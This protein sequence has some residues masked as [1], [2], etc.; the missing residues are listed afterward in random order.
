[1]SVP[2][3][4]LLAALLM[5]ASCGGAPPVQDEYYSLVLAGEGGAAPA[6]DGR[7]L[8]VGP[9]ELPDYLRRRG[10]PLQVD[11]VRIRTAN[12]HFWAEPL[13]E[14]IAKV[15]VTEIAA[16]SGM[17]VDRDAGRWTPA[18]DCRLRIEF[19]R[20]HPTNAAQ[21]TVSGRFWL[22]GQEQMIVREF[23]AVRP[24][25]SDGYATAV[26][27]LREA[28]DGVATTVV[29]ALDEVPDCRSTN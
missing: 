13:D 29:S 16:R 14:A 17:R 25:P 5:L 4:G 15:L 27:E 2:R 19:D 24:L 26:S 18:A 8:I 20:F 11:E 6:D 23:D 7:Y 10:L 3:I 22:A 28:L 21:V 9:V 12:H 1:M